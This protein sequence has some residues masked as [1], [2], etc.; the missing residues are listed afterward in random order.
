M[1][2]RILFLIV[3]VGAP[4]SAF[5]ML[6][7]GAHPAGA[8]ALTDRLPCLGLA[9]L[10]LAL[11]ALHARAGTRRSSA[12]E[13]AMWCGLATFLL[14]AAFASPYL[15][16]WAFV[17]LLCLAGTSVVRLA[18]RVRGGRTTASPFQRRIFA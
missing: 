2:N 10:A 18:D 14:V 6:Y 13:A 15:G 11:G 3:A 16:A 8:V 4:T 9:V 5:A 7:V 1:L 12:A 17:A